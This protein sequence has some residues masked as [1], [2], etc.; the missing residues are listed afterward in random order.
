MRVF[1]LSIIKS[2]LGWFFYESVVRTCFQRGLYG[3]F[4]LLWFFFPR[5]FIISYASLPWHQGSKIVVGRSMGGRVSV[6]RGYRGIY[7][8]LLNLR[9]ICVTMWDFE[10]RGKDWEEGDLGRRSA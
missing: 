6:Y 1:L 7:K 5:T 2:Y 4:F 3:I 9:I 10:V 8:Y